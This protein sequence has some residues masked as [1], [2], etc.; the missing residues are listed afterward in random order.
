MVIWLSNSSRTSPKPVRRADRYD[1]SAFCHFSDFYQAEFDRAQTN[2]CRKNCSKQLG[3]QNLICSPLLT[4]YGHFTLWHNGLPCTMI[5]N[6]PALNLFPLSFQRCVI[7]LLALTLT[8]IP[9]L[10]KFQAVTWIHPHMASFWWIAVPFCMSG[11]TN[12]PHYPRSGMRPKLAAS[13][14]MTTRIPHTIRPSANLQIEVFWTLYC[15]FIK[16]FQVVCQEFRSF[17]SLPAVIICINIL[18]QHSS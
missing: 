16:R 7:L 3:S 11:N 14:V 10:S 15:L 12:S 4:T 2:S 13:S 17:C 1:T 9:A 18:V 5:Q 8:E 6:F